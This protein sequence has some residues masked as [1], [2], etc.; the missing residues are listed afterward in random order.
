LTFLF[1]NHISTVN[2]KIKSKPPDLGANLGTFSVAA[3][4]FKHRCQLQL[5]EYINAIKKTFYLGFDIYK[6]FKKKKDLK[7]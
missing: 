6:T 1:R 3:A 2:Q 5:S 7:I 4:A